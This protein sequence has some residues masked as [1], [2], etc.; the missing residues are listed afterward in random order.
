MFGTSVKVG[1]KF[2]SLSIDIKCK[3]KT[4]ELETTLKSIATT[5]INE[6]NYGKNNNY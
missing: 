1:L 5:S 4:E 2:T 6:N 3:L